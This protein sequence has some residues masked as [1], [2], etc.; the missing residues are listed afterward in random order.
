EDDNL[1]TPN[2]TVFIGNGASSTIDSSTTSGILRS[3]D[4]RSVVETK[5]RN[6]SRSRSSSDSEDNGS[7]FEMNRSSS[8][9]QH[10]RSP[11]RPCSFQEFSETINGDLINSH[12]QQQQTVSNN[13]NENPKRR[14]FSRASS[15]ASNNRLTLNSTTDEINNDMLAS[16]N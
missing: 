6:F 14:S 13:N 8:R 7:S 4:L 1:S 11:T 9:K 15:I 12:Q 16:T 5:R 2:T 3:K 10:T